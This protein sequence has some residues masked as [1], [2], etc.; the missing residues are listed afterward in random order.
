VI[1]FNL[2][3]II[4]KNLVYIK[5]L[6]KFLLFY[7]LLQYYLQFFKESG[8]PGIGGV[9]LGL[10]DNDGRAGI[11]LTIGIFVNVTLEGIWLAFGPLSSKEEGT[12]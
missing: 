3:I 7:I 1:I 10:D 11:L 9:K 8:F 4:N 5:F 6:T 12:Y 2:K